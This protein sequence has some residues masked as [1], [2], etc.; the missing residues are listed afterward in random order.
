[1]KKKKTTFVQFLGEKILYKLAILYCK[2]LRFNSHN[3]NILSALKTNFIIAFWHDEMLAGWYYNK[4]YN[5]IALISPSKDGDIMTKIL[6]D[7]GYAVVRGS[8]NESGKKAL[9]K[10]VDELK[11]GKNLC[12]TPDGPK[13]PYHKFKVGAFVAAKR[14]S[15]PV[16]LMRVRYNKFYTFSKSWDKFKLPKLFSKIDVFYSEPI[17]VDINAT[18]DEVNKIIEQAE[19]IMEKILGK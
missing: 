19:I 18:N 6:E 13:G 2:T 7:W 8:S 9:N 15:V 11:Q 3:E 4:K 16:I 14:T 10:L 1:M 12:I 5:P 17:Y